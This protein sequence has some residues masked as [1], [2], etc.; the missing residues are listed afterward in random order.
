MSQATLDGRLVEWLR[1]NYPDCNSKAAGVYKGIPLCEEHLKLAK[2][3]DY[4]I[5]RFG[6]NYGQKI[7][8]TD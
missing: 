5:D 3:V 7:G 1:C 4:C 8:T 2:F 6:E